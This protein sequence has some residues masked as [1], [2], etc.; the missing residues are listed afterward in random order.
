MTTYAETQH[1]KKNNNNERVFLWLVKC[2]CGNKTYMCR[3]LHGTVYTEP[4]LYFT[5]T[6]LLHQNAPSLR[7][8]P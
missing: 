7:A 4:E 6:S 2:E 8:T 3:E 5:V 1:A